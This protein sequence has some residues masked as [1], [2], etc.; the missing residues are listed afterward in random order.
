MSSHIFLPLHLRYGKVVA[1]RLFVLSGVSPETLHS[2][3]RESGQGEE[4]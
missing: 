3:H 4:I 1:V 2:L